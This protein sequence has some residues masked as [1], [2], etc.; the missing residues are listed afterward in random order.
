[1][2]SFPV[3]GWICGNFVF[4]GGD[5]AVLRDAFPVDFYLTFVLSNCRI[6]VVWCTL[7]QYPV[8]ALRF[9]DNRRRGRVTVLRLVAF[10]FVQLPALAGQLSCENNT[11]KEKTPVPPCQF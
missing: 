5:R 1:M 6:I 7:P 9:I 4:S 8:G 10:Q 3:S 11:P 2:R